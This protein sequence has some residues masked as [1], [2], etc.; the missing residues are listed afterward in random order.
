MQRSASARRT[1]PS[2]E[3]VVVVRD[4]ATAPRRRGLLR[5]RRLDGSGCLDG[6]HLALVLGLLLRLHR[7]ARG[8]YAMGESALSGR[9]RQLRGSLLSRDAQVHVRARVRARTHLGLPQGDHRAVD[10]YWLLGACVEG[11][12]GTLAELELDECVVGFAL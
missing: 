9:V 5:G 7:G 11:G 1:G 4:Q 2:A 12:L 10:Q 8:L 6:R 3:E